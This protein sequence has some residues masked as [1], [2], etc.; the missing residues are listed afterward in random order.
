MLC[1]QGLAGSSP[2][3][4]TISKTTPHF[5]TKKWGVVFAVNECY[6]KFEVFENMAKKSFRRTWN[7]R[8]TVIG[9]F[10]VDVAQKVCSGKPT[11]S[12]HLGGD[13][14]HARRHMFTEVKTSG[15]SGGQLF[16]KFS[17]NNTTMTWRSLTVNT[18]LCSIRTVDG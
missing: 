17:F 10:G 18:Q 16:E 13:L 4:G 3:L 1:P 9:Q 15:L 12:N 8:L 14:Y 2:A 5:L 11:A 6:I 7:G